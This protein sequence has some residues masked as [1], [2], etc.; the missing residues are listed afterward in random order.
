MIVEL[1]GYLGGVSYSFIEDLDSIY[2]F[3]L[4]FSN[5]NDLCYPFPNFEKVNFFFHEKKN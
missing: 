3:F 1:I 2:A 4:F 5:V